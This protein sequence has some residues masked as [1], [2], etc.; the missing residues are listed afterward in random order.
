MHL[1]TAIFGQTLEACEE[2]A[3]NVDNDEG[4]KMCMKQVTE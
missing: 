3:A 1:I 4:A 2:G